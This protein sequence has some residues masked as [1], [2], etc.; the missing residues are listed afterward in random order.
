MLGPTATLAN[1]GKPGEKRMNRQQIES[2][3]HLY[4]THPAI[5]A[6]RAVLHGQ[7][8]S[9]GIVLKR[10][11]KVVELTPTFKHHVDEVWL[12]FAS[13][14]IDSFLKFGY[15][16]VVYDED[17]SSLLRQ[18]QRRL[19]AA[20]GRTS[21]VSNLVPIVPSVDTYDLSYVHAG[22]A[23]FR[24]K[25][26]VHNMT[27]GANSRVE[28]DARVIIRSHPDANGNLNSPMSVVFEQGSFVSAL[29][30]L[31]L[32]AETTNSRPRLWTQMR[33]PKGNQ[34]LDP[35]SLF[36]DTTSRDLQNSQTNEDS[37]GQVNALALQ[38]EM[39][40]IINRLQTTSAAPGLD[41][42]TGSFSG[43]GGSGS[44]SHVPPEAS[45]LRTRTLGPLTQTHSCFGRYN[46]LC[47]WFPKVRVP[48]HALTATL[49]PTM[50]ACAAEQE[51][52]PSAGSMP[53]TRGD[54]EGLSRL[55]LEQIAA[56]LGVPADLIFNG[57][58]ASKSTAQ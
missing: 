45:V 43:G 44:K 57:R 56:A 16:V 11:G 9:S 14:V 13:D 42:N 18:R 32:Q 26:L 25:Y 23:G 21:E 41:I 17:D 12:P 50:R 48:A 8:I 5:A 40:K 7:L 51:L 52:A 22:K 38:Q 24:R 39:C 15:A 58:F 1:T 55:A 34:T 49:D 3:Q 31:A 30:E 20:T 33:A 2:I 10:D 35:Q 28:E 53:Q 46:P 19:T 4:N 47:L 37:S 27:P 36:F 54:L 29:T 6:A